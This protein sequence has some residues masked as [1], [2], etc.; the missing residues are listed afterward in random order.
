MAKP[1]SAVAEEVATRARG[2]N[3]YVQRMERLHDKGELSLTDLSRVHAGAFVAFQAYA[4]KSLERLFLGTI[5]GRYVGSDVR[6]LIEVRSDVVA[7]AVMTGGRNYTAWLPYEMNTEKRADA[8]LSSGRPFSRLSPGEKR[9]LDRLAVLRNSLA[10]ESSWAL[11]QFRKHYTDGKALPPG[12]LSP[13]GYLRGHHSAGQ[14][15]FSYHLAEAVAVFKT[16]C[17]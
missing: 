8:F 15:R 7:R 11:R 9:T 14:T 13:S 17:R 5:R 1:L 10:H 16:L 6:A 4:E 2:L 12:Q 3:A